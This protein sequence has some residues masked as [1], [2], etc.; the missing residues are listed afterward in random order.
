VV[1]IAYNFYS[2]GDHVFLEHPG[3]EEPSIFKGFT[4]Q[5]AGRYAYAMQE[6]L[7]GNAIMIDLPLLDEFNA[8]GGIATF[9]NTGG[10][11]I[12][13]QIWENWT[14]NPLELF[15]RMPT[16]EE[17]EQVDEDVFKQI[18]FFYTAGDTED[19]LNDFFAQLFISTGNNRI[20]LLAGFIP[21][22]SFATGH[23]GISRLAQRNFDM[24]SDSL[25]ED[26]WPRLDESDE[27]KQGW[28][29]SDIVNVAFPYTHLVFETIIQEAN[30]ESN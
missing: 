14:L 8:P 11:T 2:S 3:T 28:W 29:H 20:R 24:N 12:N 10:W 9:S 15:R 4:D 16:R 17:L 23:E 21:S 22:T 6:K 5:W 1:P 18:P 19:L 25:R 30:N 26:G 13:T 7:K 27:W